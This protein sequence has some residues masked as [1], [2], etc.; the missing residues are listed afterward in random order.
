MQMKKIDNFLTQIK[1]ADDPVKALIEDLTRAHVAEDPAGLK[2]ILKKIQACLYED[3]PL[4]FI[5]AATLLQTEPPPADQVLENTYDAGDKVATISASKLMKTFFILQKAICLAVGKTFLIWK[6]SRPRR[7]AIIQL[8]VRGHHYWRRIKRL[9]ERLKVNADDLKDNLLIL[10]ARGLGI[11]GPEGVERVKQALLDFHPDVIMFDPLY[12][13]SVGA[14]NRA[15]DMKIILNAFDELAEETGATVD[16]THH[17]AKGSPGDRDIRDRGAG[18]GVLGRD[19]DC[20]FTLTAHATDPDV[21]VVETILRNYRPQDPLTIQFVEDEYAGGYCF[22]LRPDIMPDKKTS[23][24]KQQQPA[25]SIYL[26]IAKLILGDDEMEIAP[27]KLKFKTQTGLSDHRIR[28]FF[29]WA[30]SGGNPHLITREDR[31]IGRNKKW[32]KT[33]AIFTDNDA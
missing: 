18:S 13:L 19:Y 15:E 31:G 30:T 8:E 17:D 25:F 6:V 28:S 7:V 9:C 11:T 16:Y 3:K 20:A 26:P 2:R 27:F 24:S 4:N 14:E 33:G 5:N 29:E 10:N 32:I 21:I 1:L 12:K 23:K 22:D